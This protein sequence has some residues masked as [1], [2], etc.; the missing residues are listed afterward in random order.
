M[1][2][3]KTL[4]ASTIG[5]AVTQSTQ[6]LSD[7]SDTPALDCQILLAFV[8]EKNRAWLYAH[9][10][11]NL[12]PKHQ[13]QLASL[14][15]RR[16]EGEPI[17][18][19]TGTRAFWKSELEVSSATLIP[20]PETEGLVE[21]ALSC[22]D[23]ASNQASNQATQHVLE[24]GTGTAAIAL[25]LALERPDWQI[26]ATD[27][28]PE[29][30]SIAAKNTD[31]VD[32]LTLLQSNWFENVKDRFDLVIS[33]PPYLRDWDPHFT[34]LAFEPRLA[35]AAGPDG[36]SCLT[37]IIRQAPDFLKPKGHLILEHGYDQR[38]DVLRLLAASGFTDIVAMDDLAGQ[39]RLIVA[40]WVPLGVDNER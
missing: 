19:L 17:A 21:A 2:M 13:T 18:Y 27:I 9:A 1:M 7:A 36:L 23:Q 32:N 12:Q 39:P 5:E 34:T 4:R 37:D 38:E 28:S 26:T 16:I 40:C 22:R 33:N 29:A 15:Q 11:E 3:A 35:L 8:M 20:R 10:E 24:L 14:L 6:L 25:S 31:A 30:L